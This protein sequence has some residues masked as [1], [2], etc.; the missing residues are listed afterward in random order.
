MY[1]ILAVDD[2]QTNCDFIA[3]AIS[4]IA[5]C[6]IAYNGEQAINCFNESNK[7]Q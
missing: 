3:E 7:K 6:Q 2:N 4:E 1:K 5:D